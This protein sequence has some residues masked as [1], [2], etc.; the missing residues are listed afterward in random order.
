MRF[1]FL[2]KR[3]SPF[4]F[5]IGLL[6]LSVLAILDYETGEEVAFSV[7]YLIPIIYVTW[8]SGRFLAVIICIISAFTWFLIEYTT[9]V[10][11]SHYSYIIWNAIVPLSF[12][13]LTSHLLLK[14]K[15]LLHQLQLLATTDGLTGLLNNRAFKESSQ[16]ICQLSIRNQRP[17]TVGY[18]DIDNFKGVNDTLGHNIGDQ[19]LQSVAKVLKES[20]RSSDIIGRIGGD[21]F[22]ILLPEVNNQ[23]A[24]ELFEKIRNALLQNAIANQWP[25][26]FSIGVAVFP[27]APENIKQ[28]L[29]IADNLMYKVKNSGKNKLLFEE[30]SQMVLI[31]I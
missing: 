26:G 6:L 9:A 2:E 4:V 23:G 21:E 14:I 15:A 7:F 19:V 5:T 1:S 27:V 22:A 8:Y 18:I 25:I 10:H 20:A 11:Y 28:A 24:E 3:S 13:L 16:A 30:Q 29:K 17:L 12:F 31:K